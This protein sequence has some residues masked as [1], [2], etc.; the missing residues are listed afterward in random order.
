MDVIDWLQRL[1]RINSVNAFYPG[2]PG[3]RQCAEAIVRFWQEQGI[4]CW[5]EEVLPNRSNVIG[6]LP[7]VREDRRLILEAHMDTVS[8]EGM[9][10]PPFEPKIEKGKLFGR[11][12]CDTK[13]G[14]AAM[15]VAVART[16]RAGWVPP[17]EIWMAAV[18]DEEHSCQGVLRLCQG[19]RAEG[20]LVA[21][22]TELRAV[23][24]SK[25]VLRWTI[26]AHG[27][28]AHSSKLHLGVNAIQHMAR[29]LVELESHHAELALPSHPLLGS[30]SANVGLIS[31]GV[32]VNFVP[33]R[34]EIQIDR[35]M[36]PG[37]DPAV[38]LAGYQK[39]LERLQSELPNARFSMAPPSLID[40][41]LDANPESELVQTAREQL[42]RMGLDDHPTGVAFGSDASKLQRAGIDSILFG[43]GS[44][45]QAHTDAE[46]VEVEQVHLA[47]EFYSKMIREFLA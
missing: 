30:P 2:G 39:R 9:S 40:H 12:A 37:E 7:G 36:L 13:A 14:L 6:R 44:I 17:C 42:R 43:P 4:E 32:Q 26:V 22:P 15:M 19:L 23:V 21:E 41:G 8:V 16:H 5:T 34:C 28:S 45:D 3:E 47:E 27:R 35:R 11:G 25:G 24:A 31:G 20:A 29:L 33:D 10:I 1:V 46:Y 38:I 18:I